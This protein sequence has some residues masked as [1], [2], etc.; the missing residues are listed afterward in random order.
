MVLGREQARRPASAAGRGRAA[1][2]RGPATRS[3]RA[4]PAARPGPS[5]SVRLARGALAAASSRP[6]PS[7]S[8]TSRQPVPSSAAART[9]A[10]R[11]RAIAAEVLLGAGERRDAARQLQPAACARPRSARP[12]A[13]AARGRAARASSRRRRRR[14]VLDLGL[15]LGVALDRVGRELVDVGEDRLGEQA[16]RLGVEAGRGGRPRDPP[17]GDPGADPVGGLQ[18]VEGAALAQL[19]A[20]ERDVDLAARARGRRP[21]RGSGR[22]TGAAPRSTPVRMPRPKLPSSG[23]AYSGTSRAIASRISLGDRGSSGSIRS[24]TSAG[25]PRQ[26]SESSW[27]LSSN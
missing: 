6:G 14:T 24:A 16:Q 23:R 18:R 4:R 25:R 13:P 7:G 12:R 15:R 17:P 19:A 3:R 22:R 8:G 20:A 2:P 10:G 27:F 5:A 26:G 1:A 21:G 11:R 9:S